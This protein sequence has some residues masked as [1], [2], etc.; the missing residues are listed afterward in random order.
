MLT[1]LLTEARKWRR[2]SFLLVT[3]GAALASPVL[4]YLKYASAEEVVPAHEVIWQ[5]LLMHLVLTGPLIVTLIGA[6]LIAAEYQWDTW[7]INLTGRVARWRIYLAKW[8]VGV[9]WILGLTGLVGAAGRLST[10]L[11]GSPDP[12]PLWLWAKAY[13][14]GALGLSAMLGV[15]HLTTLLSRSFFFTSGVGIIGTFAG[16]MVLMSKYQ[17]VYPLSGVVVLTGSMVGMP[18]SPK[19]IGSMPL[20]I[21]IQVA[22]AVVGFGLSMLYVQKADYR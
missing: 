5:T 15:Y 13:T 16:F 7:K 19:I 22:L 6:Q 14:A 20:W 10:M 1:S 9:V 17:A 18:I 4:N 2:T 8:V 12:E 21:G 3:V 11:L